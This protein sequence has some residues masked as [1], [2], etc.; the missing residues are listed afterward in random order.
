MDEDKIHQRR[1]RCA[2]HKGAGRNPGELS[3]L[4]HFRHLRHDEFEAV[5]ITAKS[6]RA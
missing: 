2:A 1:S 4:R 5:S 6:A 3:A